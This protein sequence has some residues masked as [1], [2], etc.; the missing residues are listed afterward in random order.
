[1]KQS[2]HPGVFVA[3]IAVFLA[4][5]VYFGYRY[6][7]PEHSPYKMTKE[8]YEQQMKAH[9][10]GAGGGNSAAGGPGG[11]G[12]GGG[13]SAAGGA[14]GAG[15]GSVYPGSEGSHNGGGSGN[16]NRPRTQ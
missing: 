14:G 9:A 2:I 12:F 11:G 8:T 4:V 10:G 1:M 13:N 16:P 15:G 5:A 3:V 6:A 7:Q